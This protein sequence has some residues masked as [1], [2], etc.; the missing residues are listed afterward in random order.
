MTLYV[1]DLDGTLLNTDKE[2]SAYSKNELNKIIEKGVHFTIASARTPATVVEMLEGINLK[3]PITL[4]NGVLIYDV[5][6]EKYI[7]IKEIEKPT[8]EAIIDIYEELNKQVFIYAIKDDHL[9]VYH[10]ELINNYEKKYFDERCNR[11]LKTFV[12]VDNYKEAVKDSKVINFVI[13][14]DFQKVD[15]LHNKI[16]NIDGIIAEYHKDIYGT[17]HYFY[18]IYSKKASKANGI[19]FLQRYV[20]T[21]EIISFGDNLNDVPMFEVSTECYAM[22]N[23]VDKLKKIATATIGDNNSDAVAKFIRNRILNKTNI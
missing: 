15:E 6:K 3:L 17:G 10:K 1:S 18:E 21:K 20:E 23:A 5:N 2:I 7:D 9:F 11:T 8:V 22:G 19:K 16:K 14:D 12:K 13:L 4:M